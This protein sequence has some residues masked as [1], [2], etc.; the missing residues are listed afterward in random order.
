MKNVKKMVSIRRFLIALVAVV[1]VVAVQLFN[2]VEASAKNAEPKVDYH[3]NGQ[4][5]FVPEWD[6]YGAFVVDNLNKNA[7]VTLTVDNKKIAS[8]R[9]D[10]RQNIGWITAKKAG[11]VKAT[12]KIV[13]NKKTYTYTSKLTWAKYS[14]PL[15]SLSIGK[16]KYKV[17]YFDKN[18]MAAMKKV[19]GSQPLKVSLKKGY[20][21]TFLGI[22]RGG[23][24]KRLKNGEKINFTSK[25]SDN[26]V[27]FVNYQDPKGNYGTLRLFAD[28]SSYAFK[29]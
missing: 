5:M 11:T 4:F 18:T 10:K 3:E 6:T 26:T 1:S 16:T 15:K 7:K 17:S 24:Y 27:V 20:K 12:L 19:K 14:N 8:A 25:G 13:Q 2:P 29:E 23:Q 9:W 21:L 22:S 28:K